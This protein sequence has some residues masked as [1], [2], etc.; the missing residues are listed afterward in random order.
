M[1]RAW[2]AAP[3]EAADVARLLEAF[4][5]HLGKRSPDRP[6]FLPTVER[7]MDDPGTEFLLAAP[8][9]EAP[10]A[11]VAQIRF[12]LSVWTGAPDCWI[13]DVFVEEHARRAGLGEA[14]V[15]LALERA[16]AR[17]AWRAELD[18]SEDNAPALALYRRL[19]FSERSKGPA[20][21]LFLGR[22][23]ERG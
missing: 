7:L 9:P 16:R 3:H 13:E 20:R 22:R 14:L 2:L 18:T 23:I 5:D 6:P 17:G 10:P 1:T 15:R 19:G 4:L 21:D 12:R 11:G 8:R